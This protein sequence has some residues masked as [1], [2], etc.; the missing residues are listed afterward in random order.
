M[1]KTLSRILIV[2]LALGSAM[3]ARAQSLLPIK[4]DQRVRIWTASAEAMTGRVAT[5]NR[6]TIQIDVDGRD[7]V[8]VA[9]MTIR[10]IEVSNGQKSRGAG[11]KKGAIRGA[12]IGAAIGAISLGLQHDSVG[13]DETSVAEAVALGLWSG[14]LF[15][16]AIGA[17]IGAAHGGEKWKQVFP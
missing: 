12:L 11:A 3:P 13:E 10:K 15:G 2:L 1:Q 5:L 16:G 4:V 9:A 8:T 7:R 17:G 14:A 6:D